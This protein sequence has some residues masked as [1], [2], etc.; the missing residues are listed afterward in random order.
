MDNGFIVLHR[1][2]LD[3]PISKKPH[4]AWLWVYLIMRA[5]WEDKHIIWN[6][7]KT[8]IPKGSF[9]TGRLKLAKETGIKASTI[10]RAL[11]YLENE[12]QIEQQKNNK[13][14]VITIVNWN[15][16]QNKDSK[17]DNKRTASGQLADT[18]NNINN[19]N[20][21]TR[22][23][24]S[25]HIVSVIDAFKT[26]NSSYKKW[27]GNTTQR[28]AIKNLIETH[29]LE[30]VLQVIAILHKTNVIP[31]MPVI[32]TPLQLE[33][34]WSALESALTKK[35]NELQNKNNIAFV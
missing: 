25:S 8:I 22:N 15:K 3:N 18:D 13:Y 16:Y 33:E 5:N 10:E 28:S 30:R 14:R 11:E 4:W 31:Y 27:F 20:N 29:G 35:K 26:V 2:M 9:I 7:K 24:E 23:E 19:I 17:M 12:H 6:G 34:K 21:N 32:N 1:K